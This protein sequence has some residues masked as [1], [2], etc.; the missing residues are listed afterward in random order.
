M[1]TLEVKTRDDWRRWL[2]AHHDTESELWLVFHRKHTGLPNVPYG[3]TVEEA[4]CF[5]WVDSIIKRIDERRYARKY[6]P[7]RPGSPWSEL[8]K[9]RAT[10]MI[11]AGRM[12]PAGVTLIEHAK[13]SGE[14]TRR[15]ARPDVSADEV[16][17]ELTEALAADPEADRNFRALA[18][19]Y[20]KRYVLWIATA[21]RPDTRRR[22]TREAIQKLR[23]GEK[24]GLK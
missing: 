19:S 12:T 21:R 2:A 5:G 10:R 18:P 20:R 22:R 4:L 17:P 13:A 23:R 15:H 14:W 16:P 6:T 24:L 7:R 9:A 8:N 11:E 1:N 3:E